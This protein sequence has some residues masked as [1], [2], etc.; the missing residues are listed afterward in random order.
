MTRIPVLDATQAASWDETARDVANIPSRVLMESAGRASALIL[1]REFQSRIG[2]GVLVV[3]GHGNNG[4][5]GWVVARALHSVGIRTLA[6]DESRNRSDD[7]EANRKLALDAGVEYCEPDG[8]WPRV[9]VVVDAL[10]GTG[11]SGSPRGGLGALANRLMQLNVPV[12]AI[13]GP[14]GLDLSTGNASGPV[15]A[16]LTVTFGGAR[17]GHLLARSWCGKIVVLEMGFSP[18]DAS[19]PAIVDDRWAAELLPPLSPEMHKGDRG[20]VLVVGGDKGMAGAAMFAAKTAFVAG[21]GLVKIAAHEVS[22]GAAQET[23]PDALTVTTALGPALEPELI[24]ALNWADA[25]VLGPGLGRGEARSEFVGSVLETNESRAVI[26]ADALHV[27]LEVLSTGKAS[28]V[29]T[30]H[31]GELSAMFPDLREAVKTDRF[32]AAEH[33]AHAVVP[34]SPS[35]PPP[36]TPPPVVLLKGVPTVMAQVGSPL[37]VSAS[38][39]PSLATGGSGDLLS[40]F[41]GAFLA[42][43]LDPLDAAA[44]GAHVLGRSAELASANNTARSSRPLDV[45]EAA[46]DLWKIL[47][48]QPTPAPPVLLELESPRLV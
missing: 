11:A 5:D 25:V 27:G 15:K 38:G 1:A 46:K 9:G 40:G 30:P 39:D 24:E 44:L 12:V 35:S 18:P 22:I 26:D 32:A 43:G 8:S 6:T 31:P 29:F 45:A 33:A 10:L 47:A 19:W 48:D 13:D 23:M 7:C 4:G 42:R 3:A 36:P 41:I 2:E 21:A 34:S 20:R 14:T 17:R 37:R 28:R 16:D